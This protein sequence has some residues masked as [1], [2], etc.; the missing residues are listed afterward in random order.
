ML[1]NKSITQT[2]KCVFFLR[3]S[4]AIILVIPPRFSCLGQKAN[5]AKAQGSAFIQNVS[6]DYDVE[7]IQFFT[8]M[9]YM[10]KVL[11]K[12]Y[13]HSPWPLCSRS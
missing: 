2:K 13:H 1:E 3:V 10:Y 11:L 12:T 7:T 8:T 4:K 6:I 9:P 5:C